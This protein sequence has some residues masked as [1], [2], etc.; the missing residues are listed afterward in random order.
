MLPE[1]VQ[2]YDEPDLVSAIIKQST[3][4]WLWNQGH[5]DELSYI[6]KLWKNTKA[7]PPYIL[8]R[9]H[10][11]Y[12]GKNICTFLIQ[13]DIDEVSYDEDASEGHTHDHDHGHGSE[14]EESDH[15][16]DDHKESNQ[17]M[18]LIRN[19]IFFFFEWS[20]GIREIYFFSELYVFTFF[21]TQQ[22]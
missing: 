18:A 3:Y 14:T 9:K 19:F 16:E 10:Y 11:S 21:K 6:E 5:I 12:S 22:R 20:I 1:G 8:F 15:N 2:L 17:F 4:L 7:S 13:G